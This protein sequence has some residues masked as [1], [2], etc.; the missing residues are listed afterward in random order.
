LKKVIHIPRRFVAN[1]WGGTETTI[2]ELCKAM[3]ANGVDSKIFTSKALST[4][5]SE[6]IDGVSVSRFRHFY[7]F[8]GMN[9]E[10]I[11]Q[12]DKKAGNLFSFSLL[13][14]LLFSKSVRLI[15]LHTGKRMG[16]IGR[17]VARLRGIPY[18]VTLHGGVFD[19]P[20]SEAAAIIEPNR[21]A[22]FEWGRI[23]GALVGA[24]RVLEDA[25]AVICVGQREAELARKSLP[26]KRIEFIPNGVDISHFALGDGDKF[27]KT[28][29]IPANSRIILCLSRIDYQKNQLAL[30]EAL[31]DILS[32]APEA[33]VVLVGPT[34]V[35]SYADDL[36]GRIAE[37]GLQRNITRIGGLRY[38]DPALCD[39]YYAADLFCLP[40]LHEPF[41]IVILEAWASN[42]PVIASNVGGIPSFTR[43]E[44][45]VLLFDPSKPS[46]LVR[47]V[48]RV[49][50][51]PE[52]SQKLRI[53]GHRRAIEEFDW[54]IIG[55]RLVGLYEDLWVNSKR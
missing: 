50:D 35:Q 2:L 14:T 25:D 3:S 54:S 40:S 11:E 29:G 38:S 23:L 24:R 9:P 42:L 49:F 12:M 8:L 6:L 21:K 43:D 15:H 37:L 10:I 44:E 39:A 30:V 51:D 16:G 45:D 46:E 31:P 26:N 27:R 18:V 13:F 20:S 7:P 32:K 5:E 53:N 22:G 48:V 4:V 36:D 52:L 47:A 28:H 55:K 19:V 33:H 1:E 17:L 34:T 41:G